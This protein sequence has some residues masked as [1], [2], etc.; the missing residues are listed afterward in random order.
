MPIGVTGAIFLL[1]AVLWSAPA[2]AQDPGFVD[3]GCMFPMTGFC[4]RF[5]PDTHQIIQMQAI[6]TVVRDDRFSPAKALLG[7]FEVFP[8][9]RLLPSTEELR[10]RRA[11]AGRTISLQSAPVQ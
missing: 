5:D 10:R 8:A 4:S 2:R 7:N 1:L 3:I 11:A 9:E 6:G